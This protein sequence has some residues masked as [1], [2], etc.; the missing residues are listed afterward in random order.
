MIPIADFKIYHYVLW[1]C[2]SCNA[3]I[4]ESR[5]SEQHRQSGGHCPSCDLWYVVDW[6]KPIEFTQIKM[7]EVNP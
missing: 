6:A 4:Q 2:S 1:H 3:Q 5:K 7:E